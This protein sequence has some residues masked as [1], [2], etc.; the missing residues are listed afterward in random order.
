MR[1]FGMTASTGA[2]SIEVPWVPVHWIANVD[3]EFYTIALD[4]PE[5]PHAQLPEE[6]YLR[7]LF[8]VDLADASSVLTLVSEWGQLFEPARSWQDLGEHTRV[9]GRWVLRET[10]RTIQANVE[11]K[12][13][14]QI[15]RGVIPP[16]HTWR[17][18]DLL[19]LDESRLRIQRIRNLA[20]SVAFLGGTLSRE[21]LAVRWDTG[22]D[23]VP[24]GEDDCR[25]FVARAL[26]DALAPLQPRVF[27][28]QRSFG[29][30]APLYT[31]LAAQ[32][33]NDMV[34]GLKFRK[35]ENC[36][37]LFIRHR[38]RSTKGQHQLKGDAAVV[39]FCSVP[40]TNA[41][42][43]RQLRRRRTASRLASSGLAPER[44]SE[45]MNESLVDVM[46]WLEG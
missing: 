19:H 6:Y 25:D 38:G 22:S 7:E 23:P 9:L 10:C 5:D 2:N 20:R 26:T 15:E 39:R 16:N 1:R 18:R 8:D 27:A 46:R 37:S 11:E 14:Q 42:A 28:G 34:A 3:G 12:L 32:L 35:C 33:Y 41:H 40:C 36:G 4:L 43:S 45:Q 24:D 21:E 31:A 17:H 30:V 44:I 29:S 13:S